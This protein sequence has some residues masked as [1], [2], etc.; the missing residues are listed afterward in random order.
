MRFYRAAGQAAWRRLTEIGEAQHVAPADLYWLAEI[1]FGYVDELSAH[2]AA[3]YADERSRRPG[4]S[5]SR[6]AE[7]V[8]LLLREPQPELDVL[9]DAANTVGIRLGPSLAFYAE[10]RQVLSGRHARKDGG[11]AVLRVAVDDGARFRL[12]ARPRDAVARQSGLS[13]AELS[14]GELAR[15]LVGALQRAVAVA[16]KGV[17]SGAFNEIC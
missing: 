5:E 8:R 3:G 6:R 12:I 10:N 7:L 16:Q 1:G 4:A 14:N 13:A 15:A 2:A 17:L 11:S 9:R